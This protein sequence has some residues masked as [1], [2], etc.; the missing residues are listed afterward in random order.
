MATKK[1]MR[2]ADLVIPYVDPPKPKNESDMTGAM[3]TTMPMAAMFTRSRM[4]G[5][6]SFVYALQTWLAETPEQRRTGSTP[7]YMTVF[8]SFMALIVTYMPLFLPPPPIQGGAG[9]ATS[10]V[11]LPLFPTGN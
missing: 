8:M 9:A 5:W 4:I 2:R 6:V 11:S 7:A 3:S 1:N 10:S